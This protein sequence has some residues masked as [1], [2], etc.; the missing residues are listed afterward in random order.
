[1]KI[2]LNHFLFNL[3]LIDFKIHGYEIHQL[4]KYVF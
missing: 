1:M 4:F 2:V 3:M